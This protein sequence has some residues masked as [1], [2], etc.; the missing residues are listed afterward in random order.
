MKLFLEKDYFVDEISQEKKL[1]K[2]DKRSWCD[3]N[4]VIKD[5]GKSRLYF[6]WTLIFLSAFLIEIV[7]VP[8]TS[9]RQ[10]FEDEY[11]LNMYSILNDYTKG[12]E[13]VIDAIWIVN[14]TLSFL[15][16]IHQENENFDR[17]TT[18]AKNYVW[19]HFF[20]DILSTLYVF[21]NYSNEYSWMYYLKFLR[22][23]Y[24][25]RA[26]RILYSTIESVIMRWNL[27][28]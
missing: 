20:I 4:M 23:F 12:L 25:P 14:I 1:G 9:C 11:I 17:F 19:P 26:L 16:P 2:K 21:F 24:F 15:T 6:I 22:Y 28:K 8:Y 7:L 5:P 13:L 10:N 18:I 27:S 3:R